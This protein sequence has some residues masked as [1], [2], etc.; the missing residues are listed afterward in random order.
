MQGS[1]AVDAG[2]GEWL[3]EVDRWM[4]QE[5]GVTHRDVEDWSW[6]EAYDAQTHPRDA[7]LDALDSM[8]GV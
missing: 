1:V 2:F 8:A 4:A 3:A 6:R 7:A 5:V